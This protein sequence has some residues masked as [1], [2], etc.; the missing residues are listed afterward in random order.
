MPRIYLNG[1]HRC[2]LVRRKIGWLVGMLI[3]N[4]L[5]T[6]C[7]EETANS[8]ADP[9]RSDN[10]NGTFTNPVLFA[11][12]SDPDIVGVNGSY[13][14]TASSFNCVPGLPILH[15][16]DL[17]NWSIVNHALPRLY[18]IAF[19]K[20]QHGNGV[21][22]PALRFHDGWY[23]IYWG[24]ADRGIY[25]IRTRDPRGEWTKPLLVKQAYGN[26]DPC[27]LWDDDGKVYMVHAFAHSRAGVN[28]LLTVVELSSDGTKAIDK[29]WIVF[30]GHADHPTIEGPKFYKRNGFYYIFAPAGGV[31]T[32]WQLVLRSRNIRGP[33]EVKTVLAQG[34]TEINGPHQGGWVETPEGECWFLHFQDAKA[35]GRVLHLEPMRWIDDW[36][37]LGEDPDGDGI[38]QPVR[39]H[40]IPKVAATVETSVP[41]TS[42]DFSRSELG[43]Q[44]QWHANPRP[45]WSSVTERSGWL[46]LAAV[47]KPPYSRNL[48]DVPNLLLQKLPAPKFQA[49]CHIDAS[50]LKP[51]EVAGLLVMGQDYAY[52]G[53]ENTEAGLHVVRRSCLKAESGAAELTEASAPC[54]GDQVQLRIELTEGVVCSF[55]YRCDQQDWISI[56]RSFTAREG[57]WIGAKMGL[58]SSANSDADGTGSVDVDW[59]AVEALP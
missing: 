43:L 2:S 16:R 24:D 9:W 32:G 21:W 55:G 23:Y 49:L 5:R 45:D 7:A 1:R 53:V 8:S 35:Y 42:D 33:Y 39:V 28:S 19:D 22:A 13:F 31:S 15:S 51:G 56:G 52:V 27:P 11:D 18:D 3:F 26:I 34:F 59:F 10:G 30:D 48:W 40:Q 58:F 17:V 29:G 25:M 4:I 54:A 44:W 20:S 6:G 12:Y 41:A 36:P 47:P 37:R 14:L 57:K 46:R 38:G 50:E